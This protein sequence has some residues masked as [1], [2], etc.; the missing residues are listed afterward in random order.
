MIDA[1]AESG[2]PVAIGALSRR[3]P[4]IDQLLCS[5]ELILAGAEDPI[6]IAAIRELASSP[7]AS[8][9]EAPLLTAVELAPSGAAV[10]LPLAGIGCPGAW[11][12]PIDGALM[13]HAEATRLGGGSDTH[14]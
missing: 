11:M 8:G 12:D 2:V 1:F 3:D 6:G 13:D 4:S 9:G 14:R 5:F 10:V 7:A